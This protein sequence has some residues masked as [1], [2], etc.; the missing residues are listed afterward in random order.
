VRPVD[1]QPAFF[2]VSN[3]VRRILFYLIIAV[4]VLCVFLTLLSLLYNTRF[5]FLKVIDFPREQTLV[6]CLICLVAFVAINR[7]WV[8]SA[9]L[10]VLGLIAAAALLASIILPYTPFWPK[11]APDAG[12]AAASRA[13][14]VSLVVANVLMKNRNADGFLHIVD[15]ANPDMVLAMETNKWWAG[16]LESLKERYPYTILYPLDNT[17]GM[18]LYSKLPYIRFLEHDSV[19]SFQVEAKLPGGSWFILHAVHPVP[20]VPSPYPDNIRKEGQKEVVLLKIGEMVAAHVAPTVIA[21]DFND[22]AWSST[23]RLFGQKSK[24]NDVR[25]GRGFYNS[26]NAHS[27]IMRWPLDQI[28]VSSHFRVLELKR[29]SKY[30]S[31]HFPMYVQLVL[32]PP[33]GD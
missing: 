20:P 2:L 7:R 22:V 6:A 11:A 16:H 31:D 3:M 12:T 29:L 8:T 1:I 13:N 23:S 21:G 28:Y 4:G 27:F 26:F 25:V 5:W 10:L 15:E 32:Q 18:L 9:V 14:T 24:L 33:A 30:G 19:P 17:Y